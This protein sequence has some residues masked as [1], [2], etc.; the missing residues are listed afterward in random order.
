MLLEQWD[1]IG[2]QQCC[3]IYVTFSIFLSGCKLSVP[4][5]N[6]IFPHCSSQRYAKKQYLALRKYVF[7]KTDFLWSFLK[8]VLRGVSPPAARWAGG[9]CAKRNGGTKRS[10]APEK[11]HT[12]KRVYT[13]LCEHFVHAVAVGEDR[14]VVKGDRNCDIL[15]CTLG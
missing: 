8:Y 5:G 3:H 6:Q 12:Q 1:R 2:F 10:G 4:R 14:N 11:K 7:R 9:P 13:S 15:A